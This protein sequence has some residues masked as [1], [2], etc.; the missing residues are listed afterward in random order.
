MD[1]MTTMA[2]GNPMLDMD[3]ERKEKASYEF[4][5]GSMPKMCTCACLFVSSGHYLTHAFWQEEAMLREYYTSTAQ[6]D[7]FAGLMTPR[8]RQWIVNIQLQQLKVFSVN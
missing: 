6:S 1:R 3:I 5:S 2:T 4:F 8:E 7:E